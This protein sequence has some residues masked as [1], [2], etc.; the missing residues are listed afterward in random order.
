MTAAPIDTVL[1][2]LEKVRQRQPGQYSAR[3]P[4]HADNSPSLSVRETGEGS[5]LLHCFSGCNVAEIVGA[6]GL[7]MSDLFPP[8]LLSGNEPKRHA[9]LINASQA[10]ELLDTEA[11]VVAIAA[12]N[13]AQGV[14]LLTL[15]RDRLS[16][17][18]HRIHWLRD[19]S[20]HMM[21]GRHV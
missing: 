1:S 17:A 20:G 9:R 14:A 10:L 5:V 12:A 7:D 3:C 8:R 6:L 19:E 4:A 2:R 11:L 21:G 16:Q 13:I 18:A 15:D